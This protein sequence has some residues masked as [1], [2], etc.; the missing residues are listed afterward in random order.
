MAVLFAVWAAGVGLH[1]VRIV[2]GCRLAIKLRRTA[3]PLDADLLNPLLA[4]LR[5]ALGVSDLTLIATSRDIGSPITVGI[6]S[7]VVLVP[8]SLWT[9]LPR[10]QLRD[11]L[12]HECAH[13]IRRDCLVGL[14]QRAIVA[15]YWPHPLIRLVSRQL[16][17][18]REEICDNFVLRRTAA[19]QYGQLLFELAQ[20]S[21]YVERRPT[22][23]PLMR[24]AI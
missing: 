2:H 23:S 21:Q 1:L 4:Q 7:P 16:S 3:V 5:D 24:Q 15:L 20:R 17:R 10:D 22:A 13:A 14:V 18:A 6:L 8:E 9:G 12:L 11:V 19:V